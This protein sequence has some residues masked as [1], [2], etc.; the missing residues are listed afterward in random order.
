[1]S[2]AEA[3]AWLADHFDVSR[4]TWERLE[5]LVAAVVEENARQN[6]VAASTIPDIWQRHIVDSAQLLLYAKG[7]WMDL[8]SGPGF[9][10]LVV[11]ALTDQPMTLVESRR[12]RVEFLEGAVARMGLAD[13]VSV[14]GRRLE[15][16]ATRPFAVISARAFAPLDKLLALAHRFST[17]ET[18]WVLP[19]G[20][21][22]QD[23]LDQVRRT[24]QGVFR[25]EP[26]VTDPAAGV[27][28]ATDVRPRNIK[29]GKAR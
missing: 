3:R 4:E 14:E 22:A 25:I 12:K 27:I 17:A 24:W 5:A 10:G 13:R 6:L 20:R 11:A 9:P 15:L 2:E 26:S 19:K 28:V 21:S 7:A 29:P 23:E 16:V 18:Q 8:G 1:M